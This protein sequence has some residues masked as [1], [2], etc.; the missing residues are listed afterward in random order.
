[1]P[2]GAASVSRQ[3][4]DSWEPYADGILAMH[5]NA[6]PV[7]AQHNMYLRRAALACG[8]ISSLQALQMP[9]GLD[10]LFKKYA[11]FFPDEGRWEPY[12]ETALRELLSARPVSE[13]PSIMQDLTAIGEHLQAHPEL[14]WLDGIAKSLTTGLQKAIQFPEVAS[15]PHLN[16]SQAAYLGAAAVTA[17]IAESREDGMRWTRIAF[18]QLPEI[19]PYL[20]RRHYRSTTNTLSEIPLLSDNFNEIFRDW[21]NGKANLIRASTFI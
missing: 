21:A 14:P 4:A 11:G 13:T 2:D 6:L 5:A 18:G 8:Y 16:I 3:F 19:Y 10:G 7:V 9:G 20:D 17:I 12:I 15:F 1:L